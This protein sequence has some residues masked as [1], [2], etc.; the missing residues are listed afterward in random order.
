MNTTKI[1]I[2]SVLAVKLMLPFFFL[3]IGFQS[4]SQQNEQKFVIRTYGLPSW[5]DYDKICDSIS[6][7]WNIFYRAVAG[8]VVTDQF[9]DS[10]EHLND[11]TYQRLEEQYGQ[12][13]KAD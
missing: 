10:I 5:D 6:K 2:R 9:V 7:K 8:C 1:H 3:L 4:L 11:I 12:N 13:W